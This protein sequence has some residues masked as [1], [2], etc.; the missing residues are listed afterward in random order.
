MSRLN[1]KVAKAMRKMSRYR[2]GPHPG[3]EFPGI[4]HFVKT[5]DGRVE[6]IT[7]A[8]R[9]KPGPKANYRKLKRGWKRLETT[10][11]SNP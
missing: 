2:P 7:K 9:L 5:I 3:Y 11:A 4:H 6:P 1:A 10:R 8:V